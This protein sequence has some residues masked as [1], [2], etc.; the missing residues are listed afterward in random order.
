S[1]GAQHEREGG[2]ARSQTL[3]IGYVATERYSTQ[4]YATWAADPGASMRYDEWAWLNQFTVTTPGAGAFDA[5]AL[6]GIERP[7]D[8]DEGTGILCGALLQWDTDHVQVN[9]N[10]LLER[11]LHAAD[12]SETDLLYQWQAKTL[13]HRGL[14]LG[15]QGFGAVGRWNHWAAKAQQQ[16]TL[17][18]AIFAKWGLGAGRTLTFDAAYLFGLGDGSPRDTLRVRVVENF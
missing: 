1:A 7:H 4:V 2:N 3:T 6:C 10:P 11:H 9:V 17:G 5:A 15:A 12:P 16:H 18:P 14:E 13:V 8:P